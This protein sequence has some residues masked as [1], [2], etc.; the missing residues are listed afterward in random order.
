MEKFV[1]SLK[2]QQKYNKIDVLWKCNQNNK[3]NLWYST[4]K[5]IVFLQSAYIF[6]LTLKVYLYENCR[7]IPKTF[8]LG[9]SHVAINMNKKIELCR[10]L[11][12]KPLKCPMAN[13]YP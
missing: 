6:I 1:F 11:K 7:Q 3:S 13:S 10:N 2:T 8:S 12:F 4:P 5:S 9:Q